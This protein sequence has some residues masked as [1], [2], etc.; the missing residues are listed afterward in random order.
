[1]KI[2]STS[3]FLI[4]LIVVITGNQS[5]AQLSVTPFDSTWFG[6][7]TLIGNQT[8]FLSSAKLVD[9]DNDGDLDA[10]SSKYYTGFSGTANGFVVLKN[11]GSGLFSSMPVHYNSTYPSEYLEAVDLSNDG[12]ID[13]VVSNTGGNYEGNTISVFI[14]QGDGT[15]GSQINYAVGAGPV[16]IA[17][18]DFNGDNNID[19]AVANHGFFG[20][21]NTISVLLNTGGGTFAS[22]VN[23]PAG[24]APYEIG[25]AN[26][27]S[28]NSMDLVIANGGNNADAKVNV[29]L[30]S[31]TGGFSNRTEYTVSQTGSGLFPSVWLSDVDNDNDKD[32]L[33]TNLFL[34]SVKVFRNLEASF[35][36][37]ETFEGYDF[38][39]GMMDVET[40][41]LNND[42][43][44]DIVTTSTTA[45][46][47]DG[48]QVF[49]NNGS[50]GFLL[51][52]RN[53]AGQNTVDIMLG[54]IDNDGWVDILTADSYSMQ[55]TVHKNFGQGTFPLPHLFDTGNSIA[56]S[57][58][59]ADIDGDG[60]LD[61]VTSASGRA[62]VGV[63]VKVQ[64]NLGNGIFSPGVSYSIR[65]GGVQA[66]FRDLNGDNIP[67]LLFATSINSQPYDFHYAVNNSDGTFGTVQTKSIGAC[68][69]YDIDA[70]DM[71]DN[72]SLD[73]IITEWLGCQGIPESSRRIYICLN[74]GNAVFSD[75]I[76]KVQ[77]PGVAPIA[78]GDFNNDG[79]IDVA[80]GVSGAKIEIS[81]GI[82]NGDLQLPVQYSIGSQGGATDLVVEDFNGDN[83]LD[84]A[85]SNFWETT[86][87]SILFGNGNGTFQP[88]I[89]LP[90]AYSPDLLN[91]SGITAG[92]VDSD[93]D[94]DIM[95]GNNA[96]NCISLY[97]NNNGVFIYNMRIGGYSGVSS[98]F[99]ADFDGDGKGDIVA[100]GSLP[101][102]GSTL[103]FIKGK[104]GV[105]PIELT[106]FTALANFNEVILSWSTATELNNSGFEIQKKG[107]SENWY[108]IGFIEGSGTTQQNHNYSF[109]DYSVASG[110]YSYRLKQVDYDGS[111]KYSDIVGVEVNNIPA[112]FSLEQNYPNPFNPLTI[113]KYSL[114]EPGKFTLKL[115]DILGNEVAILE[116]G[117]K[118]RGNYNLNFNASNFASGIYMY[119]LQNSKGIVTKK[120]LLLK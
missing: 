65:D 53:P 43:W 12:F 109:T 1:M 5:E 59:A 63:T 15:F 111:F 35:S 55:I 66:K 32:I 42:G 116:D 45:R 30:N 118:E 107:K 92:D 57:V 18:G 54:D 47:T 104:T 64:K 120:M 16:G 89:I 81:L 99:F 98:P 11:N 8:Y 7:N 75:P 38:S 76:I 103:M 90:S 20:V 84:I 100:V 96:S 13:V 27:N 28:D 88:A 4:F 51:P 23:Y 62:V 50:G 24:I 40:A 85:S 115:Y 68:G 67:D 91:V 46:T 86:T 79:N 102:S 48:Y 82:G 106:S 52:Y 73:V 83:N 87:M 93:G 114:P 25:A 94:F 17:A 56:G 34:S 21:G 101:P 117:Y 9:I 112:Q 10:V 74:Q 49:M 70:I 60:D 58:D 119:Q 2:K 19:L 113:I 108:S 33:Y 77:G 3:A 78:T 97:V 29:L 22:S 95:V 36:A 110:K 41:D 14:N 37:P 44:L 31:G 69:W 72:G 26:I 6:Y 71:D 61:V 39:G 105:I 80:V